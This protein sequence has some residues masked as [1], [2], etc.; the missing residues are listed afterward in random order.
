ML[1]TWDDKYY[2]SADDSFGKAIN[3]RKATRLSNYVK[4][5]E[6]NDCI[7]RLTSQLG[8]VA[9]ANL[10]LQDKLI[11]GDDLKNN[12]S[13]SMLLTGNFTSTTMYYSI[14]NGSSSTRTTA[15]VPFPV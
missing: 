3:D 9:V 11:S 8:V 10:G 6:W 2:L 13:P 15:T 12:V 7:N 14:Y 4:K 5:A 1:I